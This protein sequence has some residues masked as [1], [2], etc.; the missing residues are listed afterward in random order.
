[1]NSIQTPDTAR[2]ANTTALLRTESHQSDGNGSESNMN[3]LT[4][5]FPEFAIPLEEANARIRTFQQYVREHMV[6]GE[7]Y[8]VIPGSTKPTL[9]KPGAEKLNAIFGYAP[10]VEITNRVEDWDKGFVSYEAKVTL[11]NKRSGGIEAEGLGSCNSRERRYARQDAAGIANTVLKM[12]KKRALI[13]ATLSAT[14]ASGLFT[15][16]LEDLDEFAGRVSMPAPRAEAPRP[17]YSQHG[18]EAAPSN[19][20]ESAPAAEPSNAPFDSGTGSAS[21]LTDAQH[22]AI[23][24][25]AN[26]VFGRPATSEDFAQLAD[27]PLEDLSKSEASALIDRLRYRLAENQSGSGTQQRNDN[28]NFQRSTSQSN[29]SDRQQ[30]PR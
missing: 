12:A 28:R 9:F 29:R 8:G 18:G 27:K 3:A 4:D 1:M 14:R 17:E 22:R 16:D 23:L 11:I 30:S 13:D 19:P 24:A 2:G 10:K 20:P 7:D 26:R 5:V 25:I 6:E 21:S 15:Q